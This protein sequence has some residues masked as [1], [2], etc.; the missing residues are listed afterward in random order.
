MKTTRNLMRRS[1]LA[2]TVV[3]AVVLAGCSGVG[4]Q[5]DANSAASES[6]SPS[7]IRAT[8]S[9]SDSV[10]LNGSQN[11]DDSSCAFKAADVF[12]GA[13]ASAPQITVSDANGTLVATK[14]L[15]QETGF[16]RE[17]A[18]EN[19]FSLGDI[20]SGEIFT[21]TVRDAEGGEHTQTV[22][23][24]QNGLEADIEY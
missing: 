14:D 3:L 2:A 11:I 18:C 21:V 22:E 8:V 9:V 20:P 15:S 6:A 10:P 13:N 1:V 23:T 5:S 7:H 24:G 17:S 4:G 16:M 12:L 19:T